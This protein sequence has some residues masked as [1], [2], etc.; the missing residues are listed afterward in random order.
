MYSDIFLLKEVY[1]CGQEASIRK[2]HKEIDDIPLCK[3]K[4]KMVSSVY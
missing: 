3:A 1:I 2:F 4:G